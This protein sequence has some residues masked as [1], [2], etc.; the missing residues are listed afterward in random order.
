MNAPSVGER[1]GLLTVVAEFQPGDLHIRVRCD[2]GTEDHRIWARDWRRTRSCGCLAGRIGDRTRKHGLST[3]PEYQVWRNMWARC[4]D[5][6]N[7]SYGDYGGRGVTVSERWREFEHFYADMG[8]RPTAQHMIE[9]IDNDGPY[10]PENCRWAT[11]SEQMRNRRPRTHCKRGHE[12]T[13]EN[14]R[15]YWGERYCRACDRERARAK[16]D[17]GAVTP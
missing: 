11:R 15:W 10:E 3:T 1:Y 6:K 12:F 8:A 5:P 13:A 17:A 9:R 4:A 16:R 7:R 2:C 14:T